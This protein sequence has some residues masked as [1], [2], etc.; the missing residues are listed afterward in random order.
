M[1]K[2]N[3]IAKVKKLLK[4]SESDNEHEASLA[5]QKASQ[6]MRDH[7]ISEAQVQRASKETL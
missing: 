7:C 6:L 5:L 4:L 1:V 2:E 3:V